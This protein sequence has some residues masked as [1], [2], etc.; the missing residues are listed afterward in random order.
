MVPWVFLGSAQAP[1]DGEV[2]SLYQRGDE[3]S[4]RVDNHQLMGSYVHGSEE[5]LA[6]LAC[7]RISGRHG[8]RVLIGGLGMGYTAG[9]ALRHLGADSQVV[10]AELV[11]EVVEWNRGP[12]AALAGH[13]LADRRLTVRVIDVAKIIRTEHEAYDAI[14]LDVDNGPEALTR[15]GNNWLYAQVGLNAAHDALRPA[16]VL[17]VWSAIENRVFSKR[18]RGI[19][20]TVDE[21]RVRARGKRGGPHHIIWLAQRGT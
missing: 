19:G 10:V 17:A 7:A 9:T 16:G 6:E 8:A 3:F 15:K 2:L 18:L 13:P 5:A 12:L 4:I 21:V 20:F 14:L 11:P 1:G